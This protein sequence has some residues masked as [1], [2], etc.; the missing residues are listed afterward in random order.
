M[1]LKITNEKENHRGLQYKDGVVEDI[2][3]FND[4]PDASCCEGGIYFSDEKDIMS[5]TDY[6]VWMRQ[7]EI[8]EDAQWLKDPEGDKWRA[9]KL[10]FHPRKELH[11]V[12]TFKWLIHQNVSMSSFR[13][14]KLLQQSCKLGKLDLIKY[15]VDNYEANV[16]CN[17][18]S[19]LQQ[20]LFNGHL[21]VAKYLFE[22]GAKNSDLDYCM[23]IATSFNHISIVKYLIEEQGNNYHLR[24]GGEYLLEIAAARGYL[25]LVKYLIEQGS[26]HEYVYGLFFETNPENIFHTS[27]VG[28]YLKSLNAK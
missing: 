9:S 27:G 28:E 2:V 23:Q 25:E 21:E 18:G 10:F 11:T 4:D 26:K 5:Y 3:P 19:P 14:N 6:G 13:I 1:Y 17:N 22:K 15:L 8:P 24:G 20:S 16:N 12:E 7:V